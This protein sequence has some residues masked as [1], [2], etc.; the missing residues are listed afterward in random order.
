MTTSSQRNE[1]RAN[2]ISAHWRLMR[3]ARLSVTATLSGRF[4]A[5]V[6]GDYS[7]VTER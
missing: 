7:F 6:E 2:G 4:E 1:S 3:P 5:L